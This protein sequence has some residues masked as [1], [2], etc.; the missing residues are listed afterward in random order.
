MTKEPIPDEKLKR[1]LDVLVNKFFRKWKGQIMDEGKWGLMM[2]DIESLMGQGQQ[3][4]IT[5]KLIM[6]FVE[7]LELRK[8][9]KYVD[10]NQP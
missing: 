3:Y 6:V 8:G 4:R 2:N 7:E 1:L 5:D 10:D 9:C